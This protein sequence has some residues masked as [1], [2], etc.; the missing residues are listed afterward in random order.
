MDLGVLV[1]LSCVFTS[2]A[3]VVI[4]GFLAILARTGGQGI[5]SFVDNLLGRGED[6]QPQPEGASARKRGIEGADG[7]Q[8]AT[9]QSL[10]QRARNLDFPAP[11]QAQAAALTTGSVLGANAMQAQSAQQAPAGSG[12]NIPDFPP[13]Q[14]QSFGTQSLGNNQFGAQS[15]QPQ[16]ASLRPRGQFSNF[17]SQAQQSGNSGFQP[18]TPSLSP[19]RPFNAGS[20]PQFPQ[21]PA[22]NQPNQFGGQQNQFGNQQP[23]QFGAQQAGGQRPPQ[24]NQFGNQQQGNQNQFGNQPPNQFGNQQNQFGT[25]QAG[26]QR[27]PQFNQF[28]N[29][30]QGNQNQ[31]GNNQPP[32]QFGNQQQGNFNAQGQQPP[33]FNPQ[34]P[35]QGQFNNQQQQFGNQN[36]QGQNQ[37]LGQNRPS[38]R[39]RPRPSDTYVPQGSIGSARD[40]R[41]GDDYDRIYDDGGDGGNNI[42]DEVGDFIDNF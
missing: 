1:T 28:G 11:N 16:Q 15:A 31:F 14:Q 8:V 7:Q 42:I 5:A 35:N 9:S 30:Q 29:Q 39:S 2:I 18:S 13:M 4:I 20:N 37:G 22:T 27:P 33:Q 17:N 6:S 19:S 38:L 21:A 41:R 12:R 24:F 10:R 40:R 23:N 34:N 25:Q 36:P 26:G 3:M 32:N